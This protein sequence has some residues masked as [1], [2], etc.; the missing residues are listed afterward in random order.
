[1]LVDNYLSN[2]LLKKPNDLPLQLK[3]AYI[4]FNSA[5][6]SSAPVERLFSAGGQLME[7]RRGKM[8]DKNFEMTLLLKYN[9]YFNIM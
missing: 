3:K 6:P 4:R 5:I 2:T 7:K 1:M 8:A 9:K